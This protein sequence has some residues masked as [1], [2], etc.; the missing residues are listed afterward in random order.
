MDPTCPSHLVSVEEVA[1]Y[2]PRLLP[3]VS[4]VNYC[5]SL[6]LLTNLAWTVFFDSLL[7]SFTTLVTNDLLFSSVAMRSHMIVF[8]LLDT[9]TFPHIWNSTSRII[10]FLLA[11][12]CLFPLPA[13]WLQAWCFSLYS[14]LMRL[15]YPNQRIKSRKLFQHFRRPYKIQLP[16]QD[17]ALSAVERIPWTT[18]EKI[19]IFLDLASPLR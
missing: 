6:N 3:S 16:W 5:F 11:L 2:S 19:L 8:L 13:Q 18:A 12:I 14:Y 4:Q 10:L 17:N 7:L 1:L 15:S 9:F